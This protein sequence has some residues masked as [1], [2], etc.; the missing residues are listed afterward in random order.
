L[1]LL[2]W[3]SLPALLEASS[4]IVISQVY[5]GGGNSGATLRSDF[6][7][8]FNRS[9]SAVSIDGWSLQYA[10]STGSSW[11]RTPLSGTIQPGHYY[12]IALAAGAGGTTNLPTADATGGTNLSATAGKI[13]LVGNGTLLTGSCPSGAVDF[14]GYGAADC[15]EGNPAAPLTNTTALVRGGSGCGDTD[16]NSSDFTATTPLPRNSSTT[17]A[18]CGSTSTPAPTPPPTTSATRTLGTAPLVFPHFAQGGGYQTS[19]T[20]NN[21]SNTAATVTVSFFSQAGALLNSTTLALGP[22]GSAR[23]AM[24]GNQLSVGWARASMNPPIDLVGTTIQLFNGAVLVMEASVLAAQPDSTLRLPVFEKDGFG[25]GVAFVNANAISSAVT[26][27]LRDAAGVTVNT[28]S[29]TLG[30]SQQTARFVSELFPG[31]A[32]FEGTLE[33]SSARP[34]SALALR[35][36]FSGIFS[37]LPVTPSPTEAYFSP[38]AGIGSRIVQEIGRAQTSIDIAIYTFTLDAI[39]DALIT[40]KA[41]GVQI[42]ILAD[43]SEANVTGSD[44]ARLEAAGFQLKRTNGGGGGIMHN[45]FAVFRWGCSA[46]GQLQLVQQCRKQQ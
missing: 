45:K 20:F 2:V 36:H 1:F 17:A 39:A 22:L 34:I 4:S 30:Q 3:F 24:I 13:A 44:I 7:E 25:T 37:T 10:S 40:A 5:G 29:I 38:H 12:L 31:T 8:L 27:T 15:A 42:R 6:V 19:F 33:L 41:R 43:S 23:T 28:G 18:P 14:V 46:H 16:N 9:G 26:M 35:Q 21:L 32:N 11:D